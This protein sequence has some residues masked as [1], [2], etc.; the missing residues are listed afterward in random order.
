MGVL[1]FQKI[2]ELIE[3]D[4]LIEGA[5]I[6]N[7]VGPSSYELRI[8]TALTL[9]D[10]IVYEISKGTE[11]AFRPQS[12]LLLGTIEKINMPLNV[13]ATMFLKSKFGRGGFI[14]WG[15]GFVDPGYKGNLTISVINMSPHPHIFTG[16]EKICHLIFQEI[17][18]TTEMPYDGVYNGAQGAQ[19]PRE[20]PML[21]LGTSIKDIVTASVT[22][23]VGG[24][25]QGAM[26]G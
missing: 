26:S 12:H 25:T 22:G 3:Q 23:F 19:G 6:E 2:K 18:G 11:F 5:D 16:G 7:C 13:C 10:N 14:P 20:K 4:N 21:V 9:S 17:A 24:L 8:G 15:Q 1:P